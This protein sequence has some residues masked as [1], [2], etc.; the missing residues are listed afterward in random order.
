M[1]R[2]IASSKIQISLIRKAKW[3]R[4]ISGER[5][6]MT[7]HWKRSLFD[8]GCRQCFLQLFYFLKESLLYWFFIAPPLCYDCRYRRNES[9]LQSVCLSS[10]SSLFAS[11]SS[12]DGSHAVTFLRPR[13]SLARE[14]CTAFMT[15]D[16]LHS[17]NLMQAESAPLIPAI[18]WF[19]KSGPLACST[20]F[21]ICRT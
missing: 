6:T 15:G 1:R 11:N 19:G 3:R 5:R 8:L 7:H 17:S 18:S 20:K 21:R 4:E 9:K 2:A 16:D 10:H 13:D 14:F 12:L